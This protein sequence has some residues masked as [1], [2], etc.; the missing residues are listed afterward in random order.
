MGSHEMGETIVRMVLLTAAALVASGAAGAAEP[1]RLDAVQLDGVTASFA[2]ARSGAAAAREGQ[3]LEERFDT[4]AAAAGASETEAGPGTVTFDGKGVMVVGVDGVAGDGGGEAGLAPAPA[5]S[6]GNVVYPGRGAIQITVIDRPGA[7]DGG[8]G[9]AMPAPAPVPVPV[10][11]TV[12]GGTV[13]GGTV[14]GGALDGGALRA[15]QSQFPSLGAMPGFAA[16]SFASG[17]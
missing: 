4:L 10:T 7:L 6:G 9:V 16:P 2:A 11:I 14:G 17:G 1:T 12:G 8:Q 15:M 5:G 13:G 3:S